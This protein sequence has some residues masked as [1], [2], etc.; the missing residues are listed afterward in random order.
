MQGIV[1]LAVGLGAAAS[2]VVGGYIV[3]G[4]GYPAGFLFL[5]GVAVIAAIW[6]LLLMPETA[7]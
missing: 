1:E 7:N 5:A 4:F 2:N 3:P 6:F